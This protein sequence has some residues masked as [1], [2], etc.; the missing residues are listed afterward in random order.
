MSVKIS[1]T[2]IT[3]N[4][5]RKL[6]AC[7]QSLA[8]VADEIVV[9]DSLSTDGT[10]AICDRHPVRFV[11]HAF[12]GYVAQKNFAAGQATHDHV[13]SLDADER[14][15]P[16]LRASILAVK[17]RWDDCD[18][19]A[20]NRANYYCGKWLRHA[21]YPDRK[22]RLWDRRKGSWGGTDPHDR[23]V[24]PR[25]RVA[26]LQGDLVHEAYLTVDEHLQQIHRF[27]EVAA[28]ARYARGER[29]SLLLHVL[30]GPIVKFLRCYVWRRGFLDGHYG[31][32][33]S[34]AAASL[35]FA[36]YLRLYEYRRRGLPGE[37]PRA[38]GRSTGG[39]TSRPS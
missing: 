2:I 25:E 24:L 4:E 35:N 26:R 10:K 21:W 39:L 20:F 14:L 22:I 3:Y 36:K 31:F 34:A 19:Y 33:Y 16:E 17:D 18:G 5:E 15:S 6:E 1:A 28:R 27:A 32:V 11:S 8:G 38:G 23:V 30:L 37:P 13:L 12:E 29:P 9:V 7:L